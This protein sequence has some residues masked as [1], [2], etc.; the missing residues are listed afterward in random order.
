MAG[1]PVPARAAAAA[2][3]GPPPVSPA[4]GA[5]APALLGQAGGAGPGA[6]SLWAKELVAGGVAGAVGKTSVAPFERAKIIYQ[7]GSGGGRTLGQLVRAI[8]RHEGPAGLFRGNGAS[9]L[10]IVPYASLHFWAYEQLR[11]GLVRRRDDGTLAGLPGARRLLHSPG[12]DLVAGSGAGALAVLCTYPLDLARTR[13][14]WA[15]SSVAGAQAAAPAGGIASTLRTA[16]QGGL[17]GLYRGIGP[18]LVGVVPYAGLKFFCYQGLKEAY[19]TAEARAGPAGSGR[20]ARH[21]PIYH[22]LCFGAVAGLLAQTVTY[23]LDV[24]RRL[25]QVQD[26]R[27]PG[28]GDFYTGAKLEGT[29]HGLRT[30]VRTAGWRPLFNGLAINYVK[31][32]PS[33]AIGFTVYDSMKTL[34]GHENSI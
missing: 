22:K 17:G 4:S 9:V 8:V 5:V 29:W 7:T 34:L 26:I 14:A 28:S 2:H 32:V 16:A 12:V 27:Q 6:G 25:I 21:V 19:F 23:P 20:D 10:R 18:T 3:A 30:I 11:R 15:T 24:V 33:T 13:L 31:V 1:E